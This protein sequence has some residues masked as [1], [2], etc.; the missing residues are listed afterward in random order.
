VCKVMRSSMSVV[1]IAKIRNGR[2]KEAI[3]D[4]LGLINYDFPSNLRSIAI[5]PNMCYYW[6]YSTGYTTDPK[7]VGCIIDLLRERISS[8][9]SISIVE[10][11]ASAMKC[12]YAFKM[13]GYE[14]L[15][16]QHKVSL[17][18]LSEEKSE[19]V[20]THVGGHSFDIRIPEV[21]KNA[22]LRINVPKIKYAMPKIKITGA[23]K[24]IFGCNPY[25]Q[26]FIYHSKLEEAIVAVN[27]V[28]NFD[29]CILDGNIVSGART[30]KL[31]LV[32]TS[33]DPVAFDSVATC[34]AGVNPKSIRYLRLASE[35]GL[36]KTAFV[37]KGISWKCFRARYPKKGIK[38]RFYS[39]G[40]DTIH[41]LHLESR[42][43]LD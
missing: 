32:M 12:R 17:V 39:I 6:D 7:F 27:K 3:L 21:I 38:S 24:N 18:N 37:F 36:G 40:F 10:S 20:T 25:P 22:D 35:E 43:G 42:L 30:R 16:K 5:K 34:I 1:S 8:K 29:L 23:L 33:T 31:G 19:K 13:L 11:D 14:S 4:S 41:R 9:V 15:A 26:K 28:M 2:F